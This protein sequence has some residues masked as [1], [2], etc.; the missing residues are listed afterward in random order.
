MKKT[1]PWILTCLLLL[2]FAISVSLC[3]ERTT[4]TYDGYLFLLQAKRL[5]QSA[6]QKVAFDQ[7]RPRGLV[8]ILTVFDWIHKTVTGSYASIR[9]Y[10][11]MMAVI[12]TLS[13][14]VWFRLAWG[15][16][17]PVTTIIFS[18]ALLLHY[19][20][21]EQGILVLADILTTGLLG[22]FWLFAFSRYQSTKLSQR[23]TWI[24]LGILGGGVALS[25]YTFFFLFP[26][27]LILGIF[28]DRKHFSKENVG[29]S[30]LSY[31]LFIEFVQRV[32]GS[33]GSGFWFSVRLHLPYARLL[34]TTA[35]TTSFV[36]REPL[37]FYILDLVHAYGPYFWG[38]LAITIIWLF[39][40]KAHQG[41]KYPPLVKL[42]FLVEFIFL[43]FHH[44]I[45]HKEARYLLPL[46]PGIF[47][48]ICLIIDK[49]Q[50]SLF[51]FAFIVA[52][53]VPLVSAV[54][55][56]KK[57]K[58]N[59]DTHFTEETERLFNYLG[60]SCKWVRACVRRVHSQQLDWTYYQFHNPALIGVTRFC[61]EP[62]DSVTGVR[63]RLFEGSF[64]DPTDQVCLIYGRSFYR[65]LPLE[66][67]RVYK[68]FSCS[69]GLCYESREFFAGVG[70][71]E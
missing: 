61:L 56:V 43:V 26:T 65:V 12:S 1:T 44:A 57:I 18:A 31:V 27:F 63:K 37:S 51:Q 42:L 68:P 39:Y 40:Q 58:A 3:L 60:D 34:S 38:L 62:E 30:V 70:E 53:F 4:D 25:K 13:L 48:F 5:T 54:Q 32:F 6:Y 17:S 69:K 2:F 28:L 66:P 22:L 24:L 59:P 15:L 64:D 11:F 46:I 36:S 52:L 29:W 9:S 35:E 23:K 49:T 14:A 41:I 10:H 55:V 7:T 71:W 33:L 8:M 67:I 19:L 50:K 47:V 20:F 16:F 45:Q 21:W